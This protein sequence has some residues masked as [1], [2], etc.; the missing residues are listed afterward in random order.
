M[1][2]CFARTGGAGVRVLGRAIMGLFDLFGADD[3]DKTEGES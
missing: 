3:A 1:S 2:D